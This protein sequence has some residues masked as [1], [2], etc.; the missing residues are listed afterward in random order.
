M[1]LE[2]SWGAT[3]LADACVSRGGLLLAGNRSRRHQPRKKDSD[4]SPGS[5]S[6]SSL[7]CQ[8]GYLSLPRRHHMACRVLPPGGPFNTFPLCRTELELVLGS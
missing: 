1:R 2:P 3:T 6:V 5:I 8:A 4:Y 7:R